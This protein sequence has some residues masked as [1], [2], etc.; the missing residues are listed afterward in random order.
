MAGQAIIIVGNTGR[1]KTTYIK[2]QLK[3]VNKNALLIYDVNKEYLDFYPEPLLDFDEFI[4][5]ATKVNKAVI[6]FEEATIFFNNRSANKELIELLVR[7]RHTENTIFLLFHS[8]RSIPRIAIELSNYMILKKTTDSPEFV[9]R[10]FEHEDLA[11]AV[12]RVKN[13]PDNFATEIIK[14]N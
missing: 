14:L 8:L 6:V 12:T 13:D 10:K 11:E 4:E 9:F 5:K 1:G 7:K 3:T 2:E